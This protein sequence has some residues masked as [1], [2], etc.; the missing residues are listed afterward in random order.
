MGITAF[1]LNKTR[2]ALILVVGILGGGIL[3]FLNY[4]SAE[5]PTITI[6]SAQVTTRYPGMSTRRVEDLITRK[7]EEKIREI[8]EVKTI[9]STSKAGLSIIS[10]E[11]HDRYFD[12]KPIWQNLRNK[13]NDVKTELPEGTVGPDVN[14]DYGLVAAATLML[15][16]SKG[17]TNRE[18]RDAARD[19]RNKLYSVPGIKRVT[20]SGVPEERV[21]LEMNNARMSQLGIIPADAAAE[22]Y[23]PRRRDHQPGHGTAG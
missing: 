20:L 7:L 11:V 9:R 2:V 22:H 13:M 14:D 5:D 16:T 10:V 3:T 17:F 15:T 12:L 21:Y 1:A 23:P 6:R 19:L 8:S 4:P 18:W